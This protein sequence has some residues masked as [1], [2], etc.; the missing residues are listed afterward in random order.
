SQ[1]ERV[2]DSLEGQSSLI[3]QSDPLRVAVN[4]ISSSGS[5]GG[6]APGIG[7][8]AGGRGAGRSAAAG[9]A[10][11]SFRDIGLMADRAAANQGRREITEMSRGIEGMAEVLRSVSGRKHVVFFSQGF[12]TTL[13]LGATDDTRRQEMLR[14]VQTTGDLSRVD[15]EEYFGSATAF[16]VLDNMIEGLRQADC[17]V[18]T[19]DA[20]GLQAGGGVDSARRGSKD[21][22]FMIA[23]GTGGDFYEN[24]NELGGAMSRMLERTSVTYLLTFQP[25]K[26]KA[27]G[28]Y[29]KL[30]VKVKDLPRR[31][32]VVHRPGWFAPDEDDP[33]NGLEQQFNAAQRLWDA[34]SGGD[35]A[36][37]AL[38][39][40]LR[41]ELQ[42]H[43]GPAYVPILVEV[44]G[45]SFLAGEPLP[46]ADRKA[47][48][49]SDQPVAEI[50]LYALSG[51]GQIVDHFAQQVPL[52]PRSAGEALTDRGFKLYAPML[53]D[54]GAYSLRVLVRNGAT[55]RTGL[56]ISRL[57]V[58]ATDA[59]TPVLLPPFFPEPTDR[60]VLIRGRRSEVSLDD[61]PVYPFFHGQT[62]Y[63]PAVRP[64]LRSGDGVP[65]FLAAYGLDA[66]VAS[67]DSALYSVVDGHQVI[68]PR[69]K[70]DPRL[71]VGDEGLAR[72]I[73]AFEVPNVPPGEYELRMTL[74]DTDGVESTRGRMRLNV[75]G[76]DD[77]GGSSLLSLS[78][79]IRFDDVPDPNQQPV[80]RAAATPPRGEDLSYDV[81]DQGYRQ[82]LDR[83][84]STSRAALAV[85]LATLETRVAGDDPQNRWSKISRTQLKI[86]RRLAARDPEALVPLLMLHHEVYREH[87]LRREPYLEFHSQSMVRELSDLYAGRGRTQGARV[88][89]ARALA[90]LGG[91]L[92]SKNRMAGAELFER[93]IELDPANEAALLG[94]AAYREK[95]GGP[96]DEAA[97]FLDRLVVQR[98]ES[99][100]GRLRLAINQLRVSTQ[101]GTVNRDEMRRAA[102]EHLRHLL[103]RPDADWIHSLAAQELARHL[104]GDR[105]LDESVDVLRG[106]IERRP[107][108]QKLHVLL[109]Y[110]LDRSRR[111]HEAGR[112]ARRVADDLATTAPAD[113]GRYNR[114]PTGALLADRE[115]LRSGAAQRMPQFEAAVAHVVKGADR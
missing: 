104:A 58:H 15:S 14:E 66:G 25:E 70:L 28:K 91:H 107:G 77:A 102:E 74:T 106:A 64:S 7:G 89:A 95:R 57:D 110:L 41:T 87:E 38:A 56:S 69:W 12:D 30:K 34:R 65:V 6:G 23:E 1:V 51:S 33:A 92:Q 17:T 18:H 47:A 54:E 90:S 80:E 88:V 67:L 60:W 85:E 113:R 76:S 112:L 2:L 50:F 24:F 55:G 46:A 73:A 48:K 19:V 61:E 11:E 59:A 31:G 36:A 71:D 115:E 22:L 10:E 93:A 82:L 39:A 79:P 83:L 29:R 100:E 86:A 4:D 101:K 108:D 3:V 78:A 96:Y 27:N 43:G 40:P 13:L 62:T 5:D 98:P 75:L 111:S 114:W 52:D 26:L 9:A 20:G 99:R 42:R 21:G 84:G 16:N 45:P 8:G 81:L 32:K 49:A 103:D 97:E 53:L 37:R 72:T 63:L 35:I 105:R 44:D 109:T 68:K 94:L